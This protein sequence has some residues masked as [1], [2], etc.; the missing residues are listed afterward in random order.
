MNITT[1]VDGTTARIHAR[2][3][4]D[5]DTLPPLRAAAAALPPQVTDLQWDLTDTPFMDV[6]GLHLLF[7]PA[8]SGPHCR[9]TVT[10]LGPQPLW[11]LLTAAEVDPGVFDLSCLLPDIPTP[12]IRPLAL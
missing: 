12:G 7:H 2:G 1:T 3:E 11:L 6:A 9:T 4:I 10:G 5:F 8:T